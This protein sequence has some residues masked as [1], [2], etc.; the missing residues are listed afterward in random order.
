MLAADCRAEG[1]QTSSGDPD[2]EGLR[3]EKM[4]ETL[5]KGI[6]LQWGGTWT[7]TYSCPTAVGL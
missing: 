5:L 3:E 2:G 4:G 6:C 7:L 1:G